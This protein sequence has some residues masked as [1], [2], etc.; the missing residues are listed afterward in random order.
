MICNVHQQENVRLLAESSAKS[1]FA[2]ELGSVHGI[3]LEQLPL[4][5]GL[6]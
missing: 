5:F 1:E 6:F 4:K 2:A 3:G